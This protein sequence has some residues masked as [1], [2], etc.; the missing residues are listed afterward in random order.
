MSAVNTILNKQFPNVNGFVGDYLH[1]TL[2]R[3]HDK[4][5]IRKKFQAQLPPSAQVHFN[6]NNHWIFTC[7]NTDSHDIIYADSLMSCNA[8]NSNVQIQIARIYGRSNS[9]LS[10]NKPKVQQ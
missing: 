2:L 5:L 3:S 6:G 8:P 9:N 10:V 1:T 4:W 7:Q